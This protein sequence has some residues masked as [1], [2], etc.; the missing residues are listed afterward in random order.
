ME[1]ILKRVKYKEVDSASGSTE[2]LKL[3]LEKYGYI[4]TFVLVLSPK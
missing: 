2:N 3:I 1:E 4:S